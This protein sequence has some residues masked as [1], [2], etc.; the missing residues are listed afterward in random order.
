MWEHKIF[1]F[2]FF[3]SNLVLFS[4]SQASNHQEIRLLVVRSFISCISI[5][6][7]WL[8]TQE[9]VE[10]K[11]FQFG[12]PLKYLVQRINQHRQKINV[13]SV[14]FNIIKSVLNVLF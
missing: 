14:T 2:H 6:T 4:R 7:E 3:I 9:M 11:R 10:I 8:H 5:R 12:F 1:A 13:F